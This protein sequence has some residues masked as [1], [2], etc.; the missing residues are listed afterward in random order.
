MTQSRAINK[1][2]QGQRGI[3]VIWFALLLPV[4]FGF[5]ALAI[6]LARLYQTKVELQNAADAAALAGAL[7]VSSPS[8][9]TFSWSN[10]VPEAQK[11]AQ[12]NYANGVLIQH[13]TIDN[14]Y[15]DASNPA[16]GLH[17]SYTAGDLP[18]VKVTIEVSATKNGGPLNFFFAPFLGI[19]SKDIQA[20][21]TAAAKLP[22]APATATTSILVQ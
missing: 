11:M 21:A 17:S 12:S 18:A 20:T 13:V 19:A 16:A 22:V 15:W 2:L 1:R 14:G 6:D 5:M 4:L 3:V 7:A 9:G 10:V 8:P